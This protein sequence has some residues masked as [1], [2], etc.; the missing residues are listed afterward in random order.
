MAGDTNPGGIAGAGGGTIAG[1]ISSAGGIGKT[2]GGTNTGGV[3]RTGGVGVFIGLDRDHDDGEAV[4]GLELIA[5]RAE[6]TMQ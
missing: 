6:G 3:T 5:L 2:G 1:G 4:T